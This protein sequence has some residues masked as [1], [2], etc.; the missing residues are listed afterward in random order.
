[1][2]VAVLTLGS[3]AVAAELSP[4]QGAIDQLLATYE[5]DPAFRALTDRALANVQTSRKA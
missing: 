3:A 5:Q 1:M 4:C 2:L